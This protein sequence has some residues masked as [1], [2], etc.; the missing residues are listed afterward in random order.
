MCAVHTVSP[1]QYTCAGHTVS[2]MECTCVQ[3]MQCRLQKCMMHAVMPVECM[4]AGH[5]VSLMECT[6]AVHAVSPKACTCAVCTVSPT[7][8]LRVV[9]AVSPKGC[10]LCP[11]IL[12]G[13][14]AGQPIHYGELVA[15][16]Q[17]LHPSDPAYSF[18][19]GLRCM[20]KLCG[21][22]RVMRADGK[23]S[24]RFRCGFPHAES[25]PMSM[26]AAAVSDLGISWFGGL[27]DSW[28]MNRVTTS[29]GLL[30]AGS[31]LLLMAALIV[32]LPVQLGGKATGTREAS[33]IS[34]P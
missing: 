26:E 23:W 33:N 13:H 22:S 34:T 14:K 16:L 2:P 19:S 3:C 1:T 4:C 29:A 10:S 18:S 6:C 20:F 5:T 15:S 17:L 30:L 25:S 11:C 28:H 7:T 24:P 8:R 9:H 31:L 21:A 32:L 27:G 12:R